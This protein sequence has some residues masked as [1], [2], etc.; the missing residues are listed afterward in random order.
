MATQAEPP[1]DETPVPQDVGPTSQRLISKISG[2]ITF[3]GTI[4]AAIVGFNTALTTCSESTVARYKAFH[5]AVEAEETFW[6]ER[7]AEYIAS[8][9]EEVRPE[10]RRRK[11]YALAAIAQRNIPTFAEHQLG[12]FDSA[13]ARESARAR[14]IDL[15]ARLILAL[16]REQAGDPLLAARQ[17]N[18]SFVE[19]L[20]SQVRPRGEVDSATPPG[21]TQD[22]P[23]AAEGIVYRSQVLAAGDPLGW[24]VD[25]FWCSGGGPVA[26]GRNYADGLTVGRQLAAI[27]SARG[28]IGNEKVGRIRLVPLPASRQG[29]RD[30]VQLP[31]SG[32]GYQ[33]RP[34]PNELI[35]ADPLR[36]LISSGPRQF[37]HVRSD[38]P[39]RWYLSIF[40]CQAGESPQPAAAETSA[41]TTNA[42]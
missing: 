22:E 17:G 18:D 33:I 41:V 39:T 30:G 11:L 31:S 23:I 1:A 26:E 16:D 5:S 19:A 38:T 24:D 7:F 9:G 27:S 2:N 15:R 12:W 28:R 25:I 6:R 14:L 8:A 10:E 29:V 13:A 40:T 20:A 37:Q 42:S 34:E 35:F 21:P 32:D 3:L 4:I 36:A